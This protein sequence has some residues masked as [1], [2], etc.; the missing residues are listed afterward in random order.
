M[1]YN[2]VVE[3]NQEDLDAEREHDQLQRDL[4]HIPTPSWGTPSEEGWGRWNDGK[5]R[6]SYDLVECTT[7]RDDTPGCDGMI[8]ID[9]IA[10]EEVDGPTPIGV[11]V[12][13]PTT[14]S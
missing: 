1:P 5:I 9:V 13:M 14:V 4:A 12:D 3:S 6:R 2:E 7:R 8:A 11:H 10:Y